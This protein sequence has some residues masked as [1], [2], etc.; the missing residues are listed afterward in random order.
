M[1]TGHKIFEIK[2]VAVM[3]KKLNLNDCREYLVDNTVE[4]ITSLLSNVS[5]PA[6]NIGYARKCLNCS[7]KE[8]C[9]HKSGELENLK[10][11]Y[12]MQPLN[13]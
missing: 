1:G 13:L 4:K 3:I 9:Y 5:M 12:E 11:P 10:L 8:L 2:M 7:D 6:K